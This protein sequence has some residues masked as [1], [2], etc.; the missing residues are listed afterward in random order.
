MSEALKLLMMKLRNPSVELV[1]EEEQQ[2][3]RDMTF[4]CVVLGKLFLQNY[5]TLS[6]S[7]ETIIL[8]RR[9]N[10]ITNYL[11]V[12]LEAPGA[13]LDPKESCKKCMETI[14]K[15]SPDRPNSISL[16]FVH[17]CSFSTSAFTSNAMESIQLETFKPSPTI[18][19][20]FSM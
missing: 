20:D 11:F 14:R 3:K 9:V 1:Q 12:M 4:T 5:R 7:E 19:R 17:L 16:L 18:E 2:V 6:K 10:H 8:Y 13:R 15:F